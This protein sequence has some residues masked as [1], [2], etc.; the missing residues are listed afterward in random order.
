[1]I[2]LEDVGDLHVFQL[3]PLIN[4]VV[5]R[6]GDGQHKQSG[7]LIVELIVFTE[8]ANLVRVFLQRVYAFE[9]LLIVVEYLKIVVPSLALLST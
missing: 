8:H 6:F 4:I 1:M 3:P 2:L 5:Q 9:T 7:H